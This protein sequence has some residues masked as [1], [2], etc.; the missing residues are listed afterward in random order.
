MTPAAL[1]T[2]PAALLTEPVRVVSVGLELFADALGAMRV[3][4]VHVD[5]RPPAGGD[6][7]LADLLARA[8]DE[9]EAG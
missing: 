3:P 5:W 8:G 9:A 1:L 4:V 2:E 6:P 7:R